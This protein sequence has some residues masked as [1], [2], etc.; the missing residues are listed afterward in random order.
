MSSNRN[1]GGPAA[2][3]KQSMTGSCRLHGRP[4][5][6]AAGGAFGLVC[7]LGVLAATSPAK[8]EMLTF[9][10]NGGSVPSISGIGA[11]PSIS[12]V[13]DGT[14]SGNYF[15]VTA[16]DSLSVNNARYSLTPNLLESEDSV[17]GIGQGHNGNG[18]AVVTLDGSYMD[19]IVSPDGG[20]TGFV[21][22]VNDLASSQP[23]V[24]QNV[25][26]AILPPSPPGEDAFVAADWK[27]SVVTTPEP[28]TAALFAVGVAGLAV[29][30]KR[31][32]KVD[33]RA[34]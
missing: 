13:F 31:R 3:G 34:A 21:F 7:L 25:Y 6:S 12:G 2:F 5:L 18:S 15:T 4:G 24:D 30:R 27:A 10:Y 9:S 11:A 20:S 33:A 14:L 28:M 26:A 1:S 23:A 29:A 32:S 8:A 16:L 19:I 22:A 17:E